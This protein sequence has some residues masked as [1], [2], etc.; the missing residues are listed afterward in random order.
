ML[1]R[2]NRPIFTPVSRIFILVLLTGGQILLPLQATAAGSNAYSRSISITNTTPSATA[3]TYH[4]S[5][6]AD[7]SYSLKTFV[8]DFCSDSPRVGQTCTAPAGFTVGGSPTATTPTVNGS[9]AAGTWTPS[10]QNSGRTFVYS[11]STSAA[12]VPGNVVA[13]DITSVTNPSGISTFYGRILT[14]II[15]SPT[16]SATSTDAFIE[17][18]S[19]ALATTSNIG[20]VFQVPESLY[21]CVYKTACGD[22]PALVIGHG[23]NAIIDSSQIDTAIAKFVIATNAQGGANVFIHGDTLKASST[24]IAPINGGNGIQATMVAGTEAFGFKISPTTGPIYA[25]TCYAD[26]GGNGYCFDNNMIPPSSTAVPIT[27]QSTPGPI[28]NNVL[29]M[30]FAATASSTTRAGAYSTV[31]DLVATAT[32]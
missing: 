7:A 19:V 22:S 2:K 12:V 31:I 23:A 28:N 13:F 27:Q 21:F 17:T 29:T 32:F 8:L 25:A 18:G 30:T 6:K 10:S 26:G 4:I 20:F 3:V 24:S 9:P 14:Y 15:A 1:Q 5:F 11:D 16:Y